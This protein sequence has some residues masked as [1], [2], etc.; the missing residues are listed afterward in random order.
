MP[1]RKTS[2]VAHDA[3]WSWATPDL[4]E[5]IRNLTD[6]IYYEHTDV[7]DSPDDLYQEVLLYLSVRP[8]DTANVAFLMR[9]A[10]WAALKQI[11]SSK[12]RQQREL[13]T[14]D[15]GW[16]EDDVHEE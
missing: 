1:R 8:D 16:N 7:L 6:A 4:L 2:D 5:Q 10:R 13:L 14:L 12:I 3:D 11:E 9:T 15:E